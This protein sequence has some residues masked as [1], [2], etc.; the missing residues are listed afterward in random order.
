MSRVMS[1][2]VV[3]VV[4]A[5]SWMV[6]ALAQGGRAERQRID[7]LTA[8]RDALRKSVIELQ[9]ERA[10]QESP[11]EMARMAREHLPL[12]PVDPLQLMTLDDVSQAVEHSGGRGGVQ[13]GADPEG[14]NAANAASE[15]S[16]VGQGDTHG[17]HSTGG[18]GHDPDR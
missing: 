10:Y 14:A 4:L 11:D 6:Y 18:E 13:H 8:E 16:D 12:E 2:V 5:V 15:P 7:A 1:V 17:V 3:G 9:A